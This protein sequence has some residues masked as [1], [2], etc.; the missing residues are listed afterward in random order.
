MKGTCLYKNH[1]QTLKATE[2][3]TKI[4]L[5]TSMPYYK[6][7]KCNI[8]PLPCSFVTFKLNWTFFCK[9]PWSDNNVWV[10]MWLIFFLG[11]LV[12]NSQIKTS[13][14]AAGNNKCVENKKPKAHITHHTSLGFYKLSFNFIHFFS[15]LFFLILFVD[16]WTHFNTFSHLIC[17]CIS[18]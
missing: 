17:E 14:Y 15:F 16:M 8:F 2:T 10:C 4:G 1:L 5:N 7:S 6:P 3:T 12:E 13:F 18:Y 9:Y 11:F